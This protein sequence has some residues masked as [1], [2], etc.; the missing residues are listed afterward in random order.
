MRQVAPP[1]WVQEQA[2]K[3]IDDVYAYVTGK[4]DEFSTQIS[5]TEPKEEGGPLY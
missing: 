3:I 2:G 4:S 5:L 1:V